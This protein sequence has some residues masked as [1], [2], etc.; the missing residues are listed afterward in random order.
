MILDYFK[1]HAQ[2]TASKNINEEF[3]WKKTSESLKQNPWKIPKKKFIF[4][5]V[6]GS[7]NEL[8]QTHV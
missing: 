6:A 8:I 7:K 3:F 5:K 4:S 1:D 2:S